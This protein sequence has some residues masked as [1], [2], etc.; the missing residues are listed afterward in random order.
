MI[1]FSGVLGSCGLWSFCLKQRWRR[2]PR[3]H[4]KETLDFSLERVCVW[5]K[6]R[7]GVLCY[8]EG[9]WYWKSIG[10]VTLATRTSWSG[11]EDGVR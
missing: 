1:D 2:Y 10:E 4:L 7:E 8:K 11:R 3:Q 9:T 6:V 5:A